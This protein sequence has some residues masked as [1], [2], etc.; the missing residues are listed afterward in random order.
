MPQLSSL[1]D[2]VLDLIFTTIKFLWY[3]SSHSRRS[4]QNLLVQFANFPA[5]HVSQFIFKDLLQVIPVTHM[6]ISH[7][8]FLI[9]PHYIL[10]TNIN[11][12]DFA[13]LSQTPNCVLLCSQHSTDIKYDG[14]L[15]T[16]LSKWWG[17]WGATG[18]LRV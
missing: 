6:D 2:T 3:F 7:Q 9:G 4:E 16:T 18:F 12:I 17:P 1:I 13:N 11:G 10:G 5:S 14:V 8:K 15:K